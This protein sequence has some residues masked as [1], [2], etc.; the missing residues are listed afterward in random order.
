[1]VRRRKITMK[2]VLELVFGTE[3]GLS[4]GSGLVF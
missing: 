2:R 4:S 3:A 1:M